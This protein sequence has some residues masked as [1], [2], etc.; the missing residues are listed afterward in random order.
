MKK[1]LIL[2]HILY[3]NKLFS[4]IYTKDEALEIFD[5]NQIDQKIILKHYQDKTLGNLFK[6][7]NPYGFN[8]S[9]NSHKNIQTNY[10][11]YTLNSK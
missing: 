2:N 6:L 1:T 10:H 5:N 7:Y 4:S 11:L 3:L 9:F 8:L